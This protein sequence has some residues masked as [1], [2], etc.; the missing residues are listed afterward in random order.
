MRQQLLLGIIY[1]LSRRII[2]CVN[3]LMRKDYHHDDHHEE[4]NSNNSN[5]SN[6]RNCF[7]ELTNRKIL[8]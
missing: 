7:S 8:I 1:E 5:N 2:K 4:N 6:K 3:P